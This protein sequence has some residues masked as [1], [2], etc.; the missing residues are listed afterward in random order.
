MA[1]ET[2][3]NGR[4]YYRKRRAGN[5]VCSEYIGAGPGAEMVAEL[6]QAA[7]DRRVKA[8]AAE[9]AAQKADLAI[10]K[11]LDQLGDLVR[12]MTT[13]ALVAG[14]YHTHKGQWRQMRV[15]DDKST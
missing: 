14:G 11:Q 9:M 3:G 4:Y 10:D 8:R 13:A 15:T 12:A 1:W 2:R 7:R 5:T 6:D